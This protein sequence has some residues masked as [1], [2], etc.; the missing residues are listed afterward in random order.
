M[1]GTS[2]DK[3]VWSPESRR[4]RSGEVREPD[5]FIFSKQI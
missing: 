2:Y 5:Y 3:D 1:S 4:L